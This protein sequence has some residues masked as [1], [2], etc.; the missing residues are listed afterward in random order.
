MTGTTDRRF[1]VRC[2]Q[3]NRI[4]C[5]VHLL[6]DPFKDDLEPTVFF[7]DRRTATAGSHSYAGGISTDDGLQFVGREVISC[8]PCRRRSPM[9][10]D[11]LRAKITAAV[12]AGSKS[13]VI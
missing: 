8:S 10:E 7:T 4:L 11:T 12:N 6:I 13:I 2:Q 5:Y 9:R 3:C 1:Q